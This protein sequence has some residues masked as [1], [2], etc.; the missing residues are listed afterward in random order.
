[1]N[2]KDISQQLLF[3]ESIN[4]SLGNF[5][6]QI[7]QSDEFQLPQV[8]DSLLTESPEQTKINKVRQVLGEKAKNLSDEE[9]ETFSAQFDYL[10]NCWLDSFEKQLFDGKTL[11]EISEI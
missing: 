9:L 8:L 3:S 6:P 10:L 4:N 5:Q 11:R 1:M 2:Q 7:P